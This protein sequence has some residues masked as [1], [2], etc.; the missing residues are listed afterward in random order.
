MSRRPKD[1]Y[2]KALTV[3]RDWARADEG[4]GW[5]DEEWRRLLGR[6]TA[7]KTE[8]EKTA[9]GLS[10][11]PLLSAAAALLVLLWGSIHVLK[12]NPGERGP[13]FRPESAAIAE[14]RPDAFSKNPDAAGSDFARPSVAHPGAAVKPG[15]VIASARRAF[16]RGEDKPAFTWISQETGLKIVW[17]TN[18]NLKLE[19]FQ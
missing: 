9:P 13:Q 10:L 17:F 6:A 5:T 18:D 12:N 16:A 19:D 3:L 11:R 4:R 15:V 14:V 8:P 1:E 2:R 7:Q